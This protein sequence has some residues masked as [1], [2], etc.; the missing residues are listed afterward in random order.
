MKKQELDDG[1]LKVMEICTTI[2]QIL[3][4]KR[5]VPL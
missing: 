2:F 4:E 5:G 1:M 3:S